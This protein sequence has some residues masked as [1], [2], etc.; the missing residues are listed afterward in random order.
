MQILHRPTLQSASITSADTAISRPSFSRRPVTK[1][2][3]EYSVL[4][5]L[6]HRYPIQTKEL[7]SWAWAV[8]LG[9]II[10]DTAMLAVRGVV[11]QGSPGAAHGPEDRQG[12]APQVGG[13][14]WTVVMSGGGVS[15]TPGGGGVRWCRWSSHGGRWRW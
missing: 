2:L 12:R 14:W 15:L 8:P 7:D 1:P 3:V 11:P 4:A 6:K 5:V 13:R 9:T 10:L